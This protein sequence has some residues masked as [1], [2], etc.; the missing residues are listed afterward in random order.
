M[1]RRIRRRM[2]GV[3]VVLAIGIAIAL[4]AGW[5]FWRT[6][7]LP[8]LNLA[9]VDP[10]IAEAIHSARA[11][12]RSAPRS[13][14]PWGHLGMVLRAHD[15]GAQ[16]NVCFSQAEWLDASD[17]RWPYLRGLTLALTDRDAA[18]PVLQRAA[19]HC[20]SNPAPR[21][22]LAELLLQQG[23]LDDAERQF[24]MVASAG[25]AE[26]RSHLGLARIAQRRGALQEAM[27]HIEHVT[28]NPLA[29]K[30]ALTLRAAIREELGAGA[31]ARADLLLAATQPDDP[32]WPDP[33]V[34]E[35]ER[36]KVGVDAQLVLADQLL[37][38]D[39][40]GEALDVLENTAR[41]APESEAAHLALGHA[42]LR[43][44]QPAQAERTLRRAVELAPASAEAHFQLGNALFL[45]DQR[46]RAAKSFR[47]AIT[48][49]AAHALAHYNLAHCLMRQDDRAGAIA[50]FRTSLR[51]R[52]DH[53]D[54]H[55][56]LG[57]LLGQDGKIGEAIEH[58]ENAVRLAP[59]DERARKLLS[60]L[61]VR[62][63][64]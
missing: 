24:R 63:G 61:R 3:V 35:V 15:F 8:E 59:A 41:I 53:A 60:D 14:A 33:M 1:G 18:I 10:A 49:N 36:L 38:Q 43:V 50:E 45:Q 9:G 40:T 20:H 7:A 58:L 29:R 6:P 21:L 27:D 64:C 54:S 26:S 30:A 62:Q 11:D 31:D 37:R 48:C 44:K 19:D 13:A 34:E 12:V 56:N 2:V 16:A 51:F 55:T 42:L 47:A 28:A 4:L 22:R 23:R 5:W 39:R 46:G 52:P 57:D 32:P 25:S 17:P